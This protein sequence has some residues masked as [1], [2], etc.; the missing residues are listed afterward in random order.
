MNITGK[1]ITIEGIEGA[2]K[3]T[4]MRHI[5][6]FLATYPLEIINTRE[7]GGTPIA[8]AIRQVLLM[9]RTDEKMTP[10]TE[11]LLMFAARSQH[12]AEIILP[13]LM[14]N[15]WVVSDRFVDASYAYQGGGRQIS[16]ENIAWLD[17]WITHSLQPDLTF[18]LDVSPEIGLARAKNRGSHDRIEQEKHDFFSRVR[19]N[20]LTR[21]KQFPD[22][23]IVIDA[24]LSEASVQ[25][26]IQ[27]HLKDFM[28]RH[29][30][31]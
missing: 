4:A 12:L 28:E 25:T 29:D 15:C 7:P 31:S 16:L 9:P 14:A 2:G 3:T 27:Q 24:T 13:A 19:A 11:L 10:E 1:F 5:M 20:Y 17:Q 26:L 22:R 21:A 30:V 8:E 23:I 18:L 6:D